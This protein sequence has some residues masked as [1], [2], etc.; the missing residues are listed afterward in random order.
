MKQHTIQAAIVLALLA[1]S[2]VHAQQAVQW[3]VS[4]GGN[5]HWYRMIVTPTPTL[6]VNAKL[7]A[8]SMGGHL[9]SIRSEGESSVCLGVCADGPVLP[10]G[11]VWLGAVQPNGE[12][13]A[14]AWVT[15]EPFDWTPGCGFSN[16][17]SG[18]GFEDRLTMTSPWTGCPWNDVAACWFIPGLLVEWDADCNSDGIVDYGQ[19]RDGTLPDYN[20]DNIPD[21][22]EAGTACVVGNYPVQWREADGGNGQWYQSVPCPVCCFASAVE[23]ARDVGAHLATLATAGEQARL[24]PVVPLGQAAKLGGYRSP[25]SDLFAGWQWITGE[26]FNS[27]LVSWADGNPGCCGPNQLWLYLQITPGPGS[28]L[29]DAFD[30]SPA[31]ADM[32]L[33]EWSADCN[34]DGIVDKGQILRGQLQDV[35]GTGIPDICEAITCDDIDLNLN[36]I[37]DG[38]DLGVLLAFWGPVSPA[39]PRA[40]IDRDGLVNGADLGILLAFWGPCPN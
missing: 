18:C 11:S 38:G 1:S 3:K 22:C 32:L 34:N 40:D 33:L 24:I 37:V 14:F 7:L 2:A 5:G 4:D 21:C 9:A 25:S 30:C 29:H 36:G 15:G 31:G 19:C 23:S 35:N 26:V 8:E 10:G 16:T 17:D 27:S 6:W 13:S 39:F 12:A 28:G 20:G